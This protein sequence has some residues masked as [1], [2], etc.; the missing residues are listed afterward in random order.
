M[1]LNFYIQ[2]QVLGNWCWAAVTSSVSFYYNGGSPWSQGALA[3]ALISP[4]CAGI[5]ADN[6]PIAPPVC[7]AVMDLAQALMLT[8][9]YAGQTPAPLTF[10][11]VAQQIS[12]NSL[13]CCQISWEAFPQSHFVVIYGCE[14]SNVIIGDPEGEIFSIP[15]QSFLAG[16]RGGLW[17]RSIGA[18]SMTA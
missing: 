2:K 12:Q 1:R 9:N 13:V 10:N 14:G 18:K 4:S 5:N 7:N 8:G 16:Y 11:D 6:A 15:Y 17:K 3:S